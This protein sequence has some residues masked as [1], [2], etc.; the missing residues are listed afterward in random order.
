MNVVKQQLDELK[1]MQNVV[2]KHSDL[3]PPEEAT[4]LKDFVNGQI[5]QC[6][7]YLKL[8]DMV[9]AL[10]P[11]TPAAPP[12]GEK[13]AEKPAEKPKKRS[14]KKQDAPVEPLTPEAP[15]PDSLFDIDDLLG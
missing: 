6:E 8:E 11:E 4:E 3:L 14:R 15:D 10:E 7:L 9:K 5:R 2:D 12:E 1:K 13:P